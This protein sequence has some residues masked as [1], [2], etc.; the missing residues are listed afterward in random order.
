LKTDLDVNEQA[1]QTAAVVS[2][3][4]LAF[5]R[6]P[7]SLNFTVLATDSFCTPCY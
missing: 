6:I 2:G 4:M 1:Q 5:L 7:S 3:F